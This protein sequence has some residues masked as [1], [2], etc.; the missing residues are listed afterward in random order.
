MGK[1]AHLLQMGEKEGLVALHLNGQ[2]AARSLTVLRVHVL[3][4][5]VHGFNNLIQ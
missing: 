3:A 1:F 4:G 5:F 2:T